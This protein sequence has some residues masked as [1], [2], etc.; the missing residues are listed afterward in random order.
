MPFRERGGWLCD[1]YFTSAV[2]RILTGESILEHAFLENFILEDKFAYLPEGMLPM[3]YP[4]DH[5]NG[6]Y[7]PN[8][9]MWFV[10]ELERYV[11]NT[12]DRN[13]AMRAKKAVD[14]LVD[15]FASYENEYDENED[16]AREPTVLRMK[17]TTPL[18]NLH[19]QVMRLSAPVHRLQLYV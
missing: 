19:R 5:N 15:F 6:N 3:C 18:R 8:W 1:S 11:R 12:G 17:E 16:D 4:A 9:G 13:F 10:I 2:E 7:I 14:G